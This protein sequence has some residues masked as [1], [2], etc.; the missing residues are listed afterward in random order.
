MAVQTGGSRKGKA[1]WDVRLCRRLAGDPSAGGAGGE[2]RGAEKMKRDQGV[3]GGDDEL[4]GTSY[5]YLDPCVCV[6]VW[7]RRT[8]YNG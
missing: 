1:R 5:S 8:P 4:L 2:E 7:Y 3:F 6:C